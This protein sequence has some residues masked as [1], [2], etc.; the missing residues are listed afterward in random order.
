[1][2][3]AKK[4]ACRAHVALGVDDVLLKLGS[5]GIFVTAPMLGVNKQWRRVALGFRRVTLKD[6]QTPSEAMYL[7]SKFAAKDSLWAR[8]HGDSMSGVSLYRWLNYNT[9]TTER[10]LHLVLHMSRDSFKKFH[11]APV[12]KTDKYTI[13][14]VKRALKVTMWHTQGV[15]GLLRRRWRA[16]RGLRNTLKIDSDSDRL[17][18]VQHIKREMFVE[19]SALSALPGYAKDEIMR[20]VSLY[21]GR[22]V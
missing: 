12:K 7:A 21:H 5:E 15:W 1:M 4:D 2:P 13:H 20:V 3:K 6:L 16:E 9:T 22:K 11:V 8:R 10:L 17:K 18:A 14:S 19:Q